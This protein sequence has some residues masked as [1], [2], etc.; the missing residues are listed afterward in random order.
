MATTAQTQQNP[1]REDQNDVNQSIPEGIGVFRQA[2]DPVPSGAYFTFKQPQETSPKIGN[3]EIRVPSNVG[4]ELLRNLDINR[5]ASILAQ[6]AVK[7]GNIEDPKASDIYRKKL[8]LALHNLNPKK[9]P[10]IAEEEPALTDN[11]IETA[12]QPLSEEP[13]T[14]KIFSSPS[15]F[16]TKSAN[17][18]SYQTP[19]EVPENSTDK[20][21][22]RPKNINKK[23]TLKIVPTTPKETKQVEQSQPEKKP[24][25]QLYE[26]LHTPQPVVEEE[27]APQPE[28]TQEK[29][30]KLQTV[31]AL[32]DTR[33][34]YI[35]SPEQ[36][37][38]PFKTSVRSPE[39]SSEQITV[40]IK[41]KESWREAL[42][43]EQKIFLKNIQTMNEEM[44][45]S[46]YV[47]SYASTLNPSSWSTVITFDADKIINDPNDVYG[48]NHEQREEVSV[49]INAMQ[50]IIVT[51]GASFALYSGLTVGKLYEETRRVAALADK[52]SQ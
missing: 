45:I 31:S 15:M 10:N 52:A 25:G 39:S 4:Y 36:L 50:K 48:L 42:S 29:N 5:L 6:E 23:P 51:T 26:E 9:Y 41:L 30:S 11:K 17:D 43:D 21:I 14:K 8:L 18:D 32:L 20:T 27:P 46:Y 13:Q 19:Q 2:K 24:L 1:I 22:F 16:L 7:I 28:T 38:G 37:G 47:K 44:F 33:L 3:S 35:T 12:T 40:P 49:V 34:G